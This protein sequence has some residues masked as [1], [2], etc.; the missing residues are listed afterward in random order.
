MVLQEACDDLQATKA[1]RREVVQAEKTLQDAH[2]A[3]EREHSAT[4]HNLENTIAALTTLEGESNR[5]LKVA[6]EGLQRTLVLHDQ[7][8][9]LGVED[10][11]AL[12]ADLAVERSQLEAAVE[13]QNEHVEKIRAWMNNHCELSLGVSSIRD[14]LS[15]RC[16]RQERDLKALDRRERSSWEQFM[17]DRT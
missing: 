1:S 16:D 6:V 15:A 10:R 5:A 3:L 8:L 7:G 14:E 9:Q 11:N 2:N 17:N 13:L 12:R 4:A